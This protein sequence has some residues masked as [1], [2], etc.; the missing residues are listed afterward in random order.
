MGV[1]AD[2]KIARGGACFIEG[3]TA[4]NF[5]AVVA[6]GQ[7]LGVLTHP[8]TRLLASSLDRN[9]D[10][11]GAT[12]APGA[13]PR[14][15]DLLGKNTDEAVANGAMLAL[16]GALER[17]IA[18]VEDSLDERPK[19]YLTGGDADVL[20]CWLESDVDLRRD[21]VLEGLALFSDGPPGAHLQ[22]KTTHA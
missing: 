3:G 11:I 13:R 8:G 19:V 7:H 22:P 21:L 1:L 5:D 15:I 18:A 9:T 12:R 16:T 17:A 14:G 20:Q 10:A 6:R 2:K 4:A